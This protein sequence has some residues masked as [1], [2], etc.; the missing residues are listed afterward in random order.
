LLREGA[1]V[2]RHT[3]IT[4]LIFKFVPRVVKCIS[5]AALPVVSRRNR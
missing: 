4:Y 2:L 5:A 1:S 3:Y